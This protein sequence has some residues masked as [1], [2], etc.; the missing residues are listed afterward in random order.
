MVDY[1]NSYVVMGGIASGKSS[2]S[3]VLAKKVNLPII[4]VEDYKHLPSLDELNKMKENKDYSKYDPIKLDDMIKFRSEHPEFKSYEELGYNPAIRKE[5]MDKYGEMADLMYKKQFENMIFKELCETLEGKYV[6]D[7][8]TTLPLHFSV[9]FGKIKKQI[10][11]REPDAIKKY[12]INEEML[13]YEASTTLLKKFKNSWYAKLPADNTKWNETAKLPTNI[14]HNQLFSDADG[15]SVCSKKV[16]DTEKL[17]E[18][19]NISENLITKEVDNIFAQEEKKKKEAEKK[20]TKEAIE[21]LKKPKKRTFWQKLGRFFSI[22]MGFGII[23]IIAEK[24]KIKKYEKKL[25]ELDAKETA[26]DGESTEQ[27]ES[28]I[29]NVTQEEI[30]K[31]QED[32]K[33]AVEEQE[34]KE[35]QE[36][37]EQEEKEDEEEKEKQDEEEGYQPGA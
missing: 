16:I 31:A 22:M 6:F 12:I 19:G 5:L 35:E 25:A 36:K 7:T 20:K 26:K 14:K 23:Q 1:Q 24:R 15:Y 2:I 27:E 11:E 30:D 28:K 8:S 13:N 9:E 37:E 10:I 3:K 33:E 21:K 4:K 29:E 18:N 32:V 17:Y 34:E